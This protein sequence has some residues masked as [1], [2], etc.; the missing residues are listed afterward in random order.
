MPLDDEELD[1]LCHRRVIIAKVLDADRL[2]DAKICQRI[3]WR[4]KIL[5]V[6]TVEKQFSFA[7]QQNKLADV[8]VFGVENGEYARSV[9]R[10]AEPVVAVL[11]W[12]RQPDWLNAVHS[13]ASLVCFR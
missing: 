13:L 1:K 7:Q 9:H 12:L 5:E 3:L 6:A 10:G 11:V 8:L 4:V 2:A